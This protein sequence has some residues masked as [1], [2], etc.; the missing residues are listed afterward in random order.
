MPDMRAETVAD[1]LFRA[2]VKRYGCPVEIHSDQ[3]RQYESAVFR[4]LCQLLEI[5][6]TRTT[7]LHPRSDGMIERMNRD[8]DVDDES[9]SVSENLPGILGGKKICP[10]EIIPVSASDGGNHSDTC[11]TDLGIPESGTRPA[12][13]SARIRNHMTISASTN[14]TRTRTITRPKRFLDIDTLDKMPEVI[15]SYCDTKYASRRN[16]K[17]ACKCR[18]FTYS[19]QTHK[20]TVDEARDLSREAYLSYTSR[21]NIETCGPQEKK[22]KRVEEDNVP[23][24]SSPEVPEVPESVDEVILQEDASEFDIES[25]QE[26]VGH[27]ASGGN[28]LELDDVY[29]SDSDTGA[30]TS[31][32]DE[33][34]DS[35]ID[36]VEIV[37]LSLITIRSSRDGVSSVRREHNFATSTHYDPRSFD[38]RGFIRHMEEELCEHAEALRRT[39]VVVEPVHS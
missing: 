20:K 24:P 13:P 2:W 37:N 39:E 29:N 15:C 19:P 34:G 25:A 17:K 12:R 26:G 16:L 27:G 23:G 22:L 36:S 32:P 33:I 11:P 1:I 5:N 3:G 30:T 6:K 14:N 35:H 38:W 18:I 7:P 28:T 8:P 4:E 21:E 10:P 31:D 9:I